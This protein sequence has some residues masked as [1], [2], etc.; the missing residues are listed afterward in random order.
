MSEERKK[1]AAVG[2]VSLDEKYIAFAS[3]NPKILKSFMPIMSI[4][5]QLRSQLDEIKKTVTSEEFI[6]HMSTL[7]EDG[8]EEE[9]KSLLNAL[10]NSD[11]FFKG[12]LTAEE[13]AELMEDIKSSIPKDSY[14][15]EHLTRK[16]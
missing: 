16:V 15:E 7:L 8:T 3:K 10:L 2:M 4:V 9:V 14:I 1:T 11:V 6:V 5:A 12:G 13:S